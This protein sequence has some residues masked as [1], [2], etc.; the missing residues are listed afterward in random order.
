VVTDLAPTVH[1][2]ETPSDQTMVTDD[3][4][5][6]LLAVGRFPARS[7]EEVRA[8]VRKTLDWERD[9]G[10]SVFVVH[11]NQPDF[12]Q[13]AQEI[14]ARIPKE[15]VSQRVDAAQEGAR[16]LL[17]AQ[18]ARE[19]TWL[20]YVGHGSL[21]LWGDEKL[22]QRQDTWP[23]PAL[24]TVWAC[25][26]AYFVHPEQDSLA[27]TWLRAPQGGAVAFVGP[28]GE[29]YVYEQTPLAKI[30]YDQIRAGKPVGDALL[31]A[32]R[33][34]GDADSDAVRSY[35]LLG[36]PALRLSPEQS[37]SSSSLPA[38]AQAL[39][40]Q[41]G[42]VAQHAPGSRTNLSQGAAPRHKLTSH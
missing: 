26:S 6:P 16:D 40:F 28:T 12:E 15:A 27:E 9:P 37:N 10:A 23:Q 25:L 31:A 41:Q 3:Q 17:L 38:P 11:D 39:A 32:W 19:N 2:Y 34:G 7:P 36:D 21:A 33:E 29:T 35:L 4:G 30:F 13:F 1:L 14:A 20:N 24:V 22:L 42:A 8:M 5:R 18:L